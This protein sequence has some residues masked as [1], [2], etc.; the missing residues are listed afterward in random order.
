MRA[1]WFSALAASLLVGAA[2]AAC[3]DAR[4]TIESPAGLLGGASLVYRGG[5]LE[6]QQACLASPELRLR[7]PRIRYQKEDRKFWAE[8]PEG[9]AD[10]WRF[11]A[12]E[13]VAEGERFELRE[14][15]F[16]RGRIAVLAERAVL[17]EGGGRLYRIEAELPGYRF[18]A[19]WG[20]LFGDRF[21]AWGV[22]ASPCR[23]GE[24]LSLTGR[25]AVF[26]VP[27]GRLLL[28]ASELYYYGLCLARPGRLILD[29]EAPPR[30]RFPLHLTYG[31]GFTLGVVGLPVPGED[32]V[33]RAGLPELTFLAS[34]IGGSGPRVRFGLASRE[35]AFSFEAGPETFALRFSIPGVRGRVFEDGRS[36]L[37]LRPDLPF[38]PFAVL[39]RDA[40]GAWVHAG[41]Y[42]RGDYRLGPAEFRP[43]LRLVWTPEGASWGAF[44][45]R[46]ELSLSGARVELGGTLR[47]GETGGYWPGLV[48]HRRFWLRG[49]YA[50]ASFSL[51]AD[52][53]EGWGVVELTRASPLWFGIR[54]GIGELG[55]RLELALGYRAP[56]PPPGGFTLTPEIGY[57]FG[58]GG[59]SRLGLEFA[60]ADGCFVYRLGARYLAEPWPGEAE[61][62]VLSMGVALP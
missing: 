2:F 29:T 52:L 47:W 9:E 39:S 34:G 36:Y 33:L 56:D 21:E 40:S 43:Y 22:R 18:R 35:G 46:F 54:K 59:V 25:H 31:D 38:A 37:E 17:G 13:L 20:E 48:E 16:R 49:S 1:R 55:G 51:H 50:D 24:A 15:L 12:K 61:G 23:N 7:A 6:L 41:I 5:V 4:Y 28:E 62:L 45:G 57:D 58:L 19:D 11:T 42:A 30:L 53:E 27:D 3:E 32:G 14:P 44:G 8:A 10:S 26:S 60:Y